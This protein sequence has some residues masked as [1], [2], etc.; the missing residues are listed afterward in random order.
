M[1]RVPHL[2]YSKRLDQLINVCNAC[3]LLDLGK[4]LTKQAHLLMAHILRAK[5]RASAQ[6]C[7]G[8][9]ICMHA[10]VLYSL[11]GCVYIW[12]PKRLRL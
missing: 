10:T 9:S 7:S 4:S 5:E 3:G 11:W 12:Q 8:D 2:C 1:A 6:P